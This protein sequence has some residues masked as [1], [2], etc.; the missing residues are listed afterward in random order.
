M[1]KL[2]K[3]DANGKAQLV[4]LIGLKGEAGP[5]GPQGATG[6]QGP[7]GQGVPV[8]G[9]AG[10]VLVK[11]TGTDY[12]ADWSGWELVHSGVHFNFY[13]LIDT[14]AIVAKDS[15]R[16]L[17]GTTSAVSNAPF[18]GF[19]QKYVQDYEK[20]I[21]SG[22]ITNMPDI[23]AQVDMDSTSLSSLTFTEF[24]GS[25]SMRYSYYASPGGSGFTIL[26]PGQCI[27]MY[28]K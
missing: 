6:P 13:Q 22:L 26:Q 3:G 28:K 25:I 23:V 16:I 4:P 15:E 10:Q 12:D 19:V 7:A 1:A 9:T 5:Q 27:A 18:G 17:S 14:I 20:D 21:P 8:G 11:K 24:L 2:Y